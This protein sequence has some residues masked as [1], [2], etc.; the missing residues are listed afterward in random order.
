MKIFVIYILFVFV[1]LFFFIF[2]FLFMNLDLFLLQ[3][4][5]Q[6][7]AKEKTSKIKT[8]VK[9]NSWVCFLLLI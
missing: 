1:F 4:L 6:K 5:A 3:F 7:N 9:R 2:I 8:L